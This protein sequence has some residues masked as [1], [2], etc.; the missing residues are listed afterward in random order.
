MPYGLS[1]GL[2]IDI[3]L[4]ELPFPDIGLGGAVLGVRAGTSSLVVA[5][6]ALLVPIRVR[7]SLI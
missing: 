6:L 3:T 7:I 2:R 1:R 4:R 5:G